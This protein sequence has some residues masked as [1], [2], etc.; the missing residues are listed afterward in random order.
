MII[1]ANQKYIDMSDVRHL[2]A[3]GE[4]NA[5]ILTFQVSKIY[6]NVDLSGCTFVM[7]AANENKNFVEQTLKKEIQD[8]F[9]LLTWTVDEYFTA[10]PGVLKLEIK[11]FKG[12]NLIIKYDLSDIVVRETVRGEGVPEIPDTAVIQ[13]EKGDK[14]DPGKDGLSA[15]EI[16]LSL[17]N[18]GTLDDFITSLKGDKGKAGQQGIQGERGEK[19]DKGDKGDT[20]LQGEKGADG[21]NGTDGK[22][23]QN[24]KSAYEIWLDLSN[25]GTESDF[26]NSLKGEKGDKGDKG[27]DGQNGS[28]GFSPTVEIAENTETSYKLLITDAN[29]SFTT[30]NLKG[31]DGSSNG[32]GSIDVDDKFSETSENPVQNKVISSEISALWNQMSNLNDLISSIPSTG[33]NICINTLFDNSNHTEYA[34]N[35]N[36]KCSHWDSR[37]FSFDET[38]IKNSAFCNEEN[39]YCI[40]FSNSFGWG[41]DVTAVYSQPVQINSS[42]I[43]IIN[44]S[45]TS[46]GDGI[47]A[48]LIR[49]PDFESEKITEFEIIPAF[50]VTNTF[51]NAIFTLSSS[52]ENG[53]YYLRFKVNTTNPTFTIK[54]ISIVN[55]E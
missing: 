6:H 41:A 40:K 51:I 46:D 38:A 2:L 18:S 20:G 55:Q 14:G 10:V 49:T 3:C 7:Q 42:S 50:Y 5:D 19:G 34:E 17:G 21:I 25:S 31:S 37:I 9:I 11:G 39:S 29:G 24:G 16:W 15:Y 12:D 36:F 53:S 22:D 8:N 13:G 54:K 35:W 45:C 52:P 44:Y 32:T 4:R 23:G 27:A 1:R 33:G 47:T 48:E 30:P 28:D 26:L 43:L